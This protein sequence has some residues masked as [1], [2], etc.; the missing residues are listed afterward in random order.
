MEARDKYLVKDIKPVDGNG[1]LV[2]YDGAL[3]PARGFPTDQIFLSMNIV[4]RVLRE[5]LKFPLLFLHSNKR[6]IESFNSIGEVSFYASVPPKYVLCPAARK[7]DDMVYIFLEEI[8][9]SPVEAALMARNIAYIFEFDNAYRYRIQDLASEA[10]EEELINNPSM[11]INRLLSI[12]LE[13]DSDPIITSKFKMF[14]RYISFALMIP[15]YKKA[16]KRAMEL[17]LNGIKYDHEDWYW[18]CQRTDY[19]YGGLSYEDRI[20]HFDVYPKLYT[21]TGLKAMVS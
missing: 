2:Y 7:I 11:E 10:I 6:L 5:S 13:R 4:K 12:F 17:G 16:F 19:L 9:I 1:V 15:K 21:L 8:G 20:K 18:V 3:Y 14:K